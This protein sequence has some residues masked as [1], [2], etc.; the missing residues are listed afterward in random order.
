MK[1]L[2]KWLVSSLVT[3]ER[4]KKGIR[5][6]NAKLAE[7]PIDE[8][9]AKTM[10]VGEDAARTLSLYLKGY[11]D[12]GKI[13]EAERQEIDANDDALVDKYWNQAAVDGFIDGLFE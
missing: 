9:K 7:K 4:L 3:K 12:D 1:T 13:D 10:G 11:A 6:A 5:R 2:L 8:A